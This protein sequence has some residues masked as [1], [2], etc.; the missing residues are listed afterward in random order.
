MQKRWI[1]MPASQVRYP[2]SRYQPGDWRWCLRAEVTMIL[3]AFA[4]QRKGWLEALGDEERSELEQRTVTFAGS[5]CSF[6]CWSEKKKGDG[7]ALDGGA[8]ED[9]GMSQFQILGS[10]R[11][12]FDEKSSTCYWKP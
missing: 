7:E 8:A 1:S 4:C 3:R 11:G 12:R 6:F 9:I 10:L 5:F 2:R